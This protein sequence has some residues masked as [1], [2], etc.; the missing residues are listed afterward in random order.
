MMRMFTI[1]LTSLLLVC[2]GLVYYMIDDANMVYVET[3][4]Y[5]KLEEKILVMGIVPKTEQSGQLLQA[6][7]TAGDLYGAHVELYECTTSQEQANLLALATQVGVDGVMLYPIDSSGYEDMLAQCTQADI[8]VVVISKRLESGTCDIFIGPSLNAERMAISACIGRVGG[9]GEIL[10]I[11]QLVV[12]QGMYLEVAKITKESQTPAYQGENPMTRIADVVE[13][14]FDGYTV[15]DVLTIKD[16]STGYNSLYYALKDLINDIEPS[17]IFSYDESLTN[18]IASCLA[19]Q[20]RTTPYVMGY[21]TL[22]ANESYLRSGEIDGLVVTEDVE[23]SALAVRFL[24]QLHIKSTM[25][26]ESGI[27]LT[28][29]FQNDLERILENYEL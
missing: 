3:A 10:I 15:T 9:E 17:A 27:G 24:K 25:P 4:D 19:A 23:A 11:D 1:G 18:T 12:E 8:P 20:Q 26:S 29:I 6:M 22:D 28:L 14:P 2:L 16:D 13:K 7:Q 21:G 5:A